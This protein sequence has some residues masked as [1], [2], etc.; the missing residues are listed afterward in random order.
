M[1]GPRAR[2]TMIVLVLFAAYSAFVVIVA[3]A[4]GKGHGSVF[5]TSIAV[6]ILLAAGALWL[7]HRIY[8]RRGARAGP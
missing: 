6:I 5:W 8:R 3:L 7:A 4:A 2:I 1:K